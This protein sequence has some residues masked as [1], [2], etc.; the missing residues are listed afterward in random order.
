LEIAKLAIYP[1][2]D[3]SAHVVGKDF[4]IDGGVTA[5]SPVGVTPV[6]HHEICWPM[7]QMGH[8]SP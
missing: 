2:S 4:L 6:V 5:I 7:S 3:D 1:G 8:F